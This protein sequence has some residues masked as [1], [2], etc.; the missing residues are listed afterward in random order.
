MNMNS[1]EYSFEP[2]GPAHDAAVMTIFNHYAEDGFAVFF[3]TALPLP[4]F[5]RLMEAI[6]GYPA[7]VVRRS[8]GP[9]VGFGFLMPF[10]PASSFR[11]TAEIA[12]FL[13][14]AH[15]G[16]GLGGLLLERLVEL[17]REKGIDNLV[18]RVSSKNQT[19]LAFHRKHGFVEAGRLNGVGHKHGQDFD[20]IL[21]Q[22]RS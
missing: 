22:R 12:Y 5:G 19:S 13:D 1:T 9:L 21:M 6:Q 15:T 16:Q 18:A 3:E 14:P 10:H 20:L 2:M 11:K 7:L 4:F 8:Q 17:G